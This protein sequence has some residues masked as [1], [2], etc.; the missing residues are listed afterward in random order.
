MDLSQGVGLDELWLSNN[1]LNKKEDD[2][3]KKKEG[4]TLVKQTDNSSGIFIDW[5]IIVFISALIFLY[6][7]WKK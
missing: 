4:P 2:E 7:F 1:P 3:V 5:K 6:F